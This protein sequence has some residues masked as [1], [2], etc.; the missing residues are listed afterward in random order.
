MSEVIKTLLYPIKS[1]AI[2]IE[3]KRALFLNAA[4][5]FDVSVLK[6][7]DLTLQQSFKPY[8]DELANAGF[9]AFHD[10]PNEAKSYD[11]VCISLPKNIIE[12]Q[13]LIAKGALLLRSGGILIC[14][15]GNKSGGSRLKKIMQNF[16]FQDL[17]EDARNKARVV[18]GA[19]TTK[20]ND[21]EIANSIV[22][23]S[24][25]DILGGEFIS[26]AGV[27][28]WDKIDKGS[29]ILAKY[30]PADLKGRGADFGCGY[31][32]LSHYILLHCKKIK[33]LYCLDADY[34]AIE[35]C[36][37]NLTK[38]E[39]SKEFIWC[40]LTKP[41]E[42]FR[43]LDFIIMNPPFHD[44]KKTDISIGQSFINEAHKSLRHGGGLYMVANNHLAYDNI[45]EEIF[46]KCSKLYE[47]QGFKMFFAVK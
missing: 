30:I 36:E 37:K 28:G 18:W 19:L 11:I 21:S 45:L 2:D 5:H 16:G 13:Y 40:D 25:Q 10:I 22:K 44:G 43:N 17:Y 12:A 35:L 29:Q 15:A 9:T 38:F 6:D 24:A 8:I 41:Q 31:G 7:L 47:G 27:F 32:Y 3:G 39:C 42:H 33:Q 34:R 4:M 20:L 46:F 23:G 1:Q 26:Q 14:A